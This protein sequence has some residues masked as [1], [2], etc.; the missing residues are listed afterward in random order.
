MYQLFL[1]RSFKSCMFFEEKKI[2]IFDMI[3][4]IIITIT[5]NAMVYRCIFSGNSFL[6]Y[7]SSF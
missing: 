4:M 1:S 7:A 5:P 3:I 6:K 2:I